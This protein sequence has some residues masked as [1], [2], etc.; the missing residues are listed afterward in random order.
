MITSPT[1]RSQLRFCS[2][3]FSPA[4]AFSFS[5][6]LSWQYCS[7]CAAVNP[8]RLTR[9]SAH[10]YAL[11]YAH[12]WKANRMPN[13]NTRK[14]ARS[15]EVCISDTH[16]SPGALFAG[17]SRMTSAPVS[18]AGS[19]SLNTAPISHMKIEIKK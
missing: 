10:L 17:P 7:T 16:L 19:K 14:L 13:A 5:H 1:I 8:T 3:V 12:K 9:G 6:L 4:V 18:A 11:T 15:R 2:C